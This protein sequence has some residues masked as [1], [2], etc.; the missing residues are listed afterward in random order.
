[1]ELLLGMVGLCLLLAA[2]S[3]LIEPSLVWYFFNDVYPSLHDGQRPLDPP[4]WWRRL[5]EG[6]LESDSGAQPINND[7]AAAAAGDPR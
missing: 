4:R 5:F 2:E 6:P 1:M 7:L 3:V